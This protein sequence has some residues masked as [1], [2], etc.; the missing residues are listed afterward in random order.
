M[1][2]HD[3]ERDAGTFVVPIR[4]ATVA[5]AA[6]LYDWEPSISDAAVTSCSMDAT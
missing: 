2:T 4:S 6:M 3:R 1:T 5:S